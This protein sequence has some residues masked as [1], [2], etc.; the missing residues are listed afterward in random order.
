[1]PRIK[2]KHG[3]T[4]KQFTFPANIKRTE[5]DEKKLKA[6]LEKSPTI[7]KKITKVEQVVALAKERKSVYHT[8]WGQ[9]VPAAYIENMQAAFIVSQIRMGWLYEYKPLKK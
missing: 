9:I 5:L 8:R 2:D 7:G 3:S 6:H 4:I 1:M